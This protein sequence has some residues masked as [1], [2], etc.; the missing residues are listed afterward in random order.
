MNDD[1]VD[2]VEESD[3][4][5]DDEENEGNNADVHNFVYLDFV[6]V[7]PCLSSDI[8]P[9]DDFSM[10]DIVRSGIYILP[11][12]CCSQHTKRSKDSITHQTSE[13]LRTPPE[14]MLATSA[15]GPTFLHKPE[16]MFEMAK[17]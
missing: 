15:L 17:R 14:V 11:W 16:D 4:D 3:G 7:I 12:C 8:S 13:R 6:Y 10:C 1:V 5:V 2:A 9:F